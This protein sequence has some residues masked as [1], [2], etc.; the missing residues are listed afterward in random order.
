M[1]AYTKTPR[2][3]TARQTTTCK[4]TGK[5]IKKGRECWLNP[6]TKNIFAVDS[7]M[8]AEFKKYPMGIFPNDKLEA[9][10]EM[11]DENA[12]P[13]PPVERSDF[14]AKAATILAG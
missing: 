2:L 9:I 7:P 6:S 1:A 14:D 4:Q 8:A 13:A 10:V 12:P 5:T 3:V 11:P